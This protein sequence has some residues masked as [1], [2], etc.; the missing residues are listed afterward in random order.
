VVDLL[1]CLTAAA[2]QGDVKRFQPFPAGVEA[3]IF[4]DDSHKEVQTI[5]FMK[6]TRMDEPDVA[7]VMQVIN[8]IPPVKDMLEYKNSSDLKDALNAI[9]P[10]CFPL[11]RWIITSNR[12]HL[13]MLPVESQISAMGTPHQFILR[14]ATPEKEKAYLAEK[15]KHGFFPAFH[16]S[17]FSNWHCILRMGLKNYSNTE[18]MSCGAAYGA[19]I[20]M[21]TNSSTS[22]G[23][24]GTTTGWKSS[25]IV[26]GSGVGL[27][28]CEVVNAGY[29][30]NP[31]YVV[32]EE[33]HVNTRLLFVYSGSG[34]VGVEASSLTIP[35]VVTLKAGK[36]AASA[37]RKGKGK[38]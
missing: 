27:A 3:R 23:Y 17:A 14:S 31:Y 6:G 15:A 34:G 20:Y 38:K 19:G 1:I 11:L 36:Q 4:K 13:E 30:A 32:P 12:T 21:A 29:T 5:G 2:G 9:D 25:S 26:S 28:V 16:G 37:A 22:F 8:H 7:K 24:A 18:M 35:D 10:L 33:N